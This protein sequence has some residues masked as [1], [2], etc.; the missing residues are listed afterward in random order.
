MATTPATP[1]PSVLS[2]IEQRVEQLIAD[3]K[4]ISQHNSD[5]RNQLERAK[6]SEREAQ[7][8]IKEL[9]K[10]LAVAVVGGA[11]PK[12]KSRAKAQINRLMREVDNCISLLSTQ[13]GC[14]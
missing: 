11:S 10:E 7:K 3:H 1:L 5:L 13:G 8:R 2:T 14:E 12:S 4:R 6:V 9:E